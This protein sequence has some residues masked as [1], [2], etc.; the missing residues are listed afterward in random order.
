VE[1][2]TS[3]LIG[4]L[5]RTVKLHL[6]AVISAENKNSYKKFLTLLEFLCIIFSET[7]E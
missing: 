2:L 6:F 3:A 7:K 5:L 4:E 1:K